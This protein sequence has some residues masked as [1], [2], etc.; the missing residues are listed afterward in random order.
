M[1]YKVGDK[2]HYSPKKGPKENGIIK[3]I[4]P[5]KGTTP[6]I[7]VVYHSNNDWDNYKN[8]TAIWTKQEDLRPGWYQHEIEPNK[9]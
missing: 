6:I 4:D 9:S 2:V 3:R 5:V 8:Y 7:Y 1:L